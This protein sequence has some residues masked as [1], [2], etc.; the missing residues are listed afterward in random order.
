MTCMFVL[1]SRRDEQDRR[2]DRLPAQTEATR[3]RK[4]CATEYE[5]SRQLSN[6]RGDQSREPVPH[7]CRLATIFVKKKRKQKPPANF[8]SQLTIYIN[9][10][11]IHI[12]VSSQNHRRFIFFHNKN[13][14][15]FHA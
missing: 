10:V 7:L 11:S 2:T 5:R 12:L 9:C 6:Q 1:Y 13:Y 3:L 4:R 15:Y 14:Y 8:S